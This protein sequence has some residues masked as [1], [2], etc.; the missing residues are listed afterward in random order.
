MRNLVVAAVLMGIAS[1]TMRGME[2]HP[3][4][5][6][7]AVRGKADPSK[8]RPSGCMMCHCVKHPDERDS[9]T[10]YEGTHANVM[11]NLFPYTICAKGNTLIVAREHKDYLDVPDEMLW[12]MT[13]LERAAV[14]ILSAKYGAKAF[15]SGASFGPE[16]ELAGATQP[17]HYHRHVVPRKKGDLS[18]MG[19]VSGVAVCTFDVLEVHA[20][21][22]PHFDGLREELRRAA[23]V[24]PCP[25]LS[26][27]LLDNGGREGADGEPGDESGWRT[28]EY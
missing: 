5:L 18:F 8:P 15:T 26:P 12:E 22:R 17:G 11:L 24:V 9:L 6:Q 23:V 16:A 3:L 19:C 4:I 14:R 28:S 10:L 20:E 2:E 21:L 27:L 7:G 25:S 13:Q 1:G